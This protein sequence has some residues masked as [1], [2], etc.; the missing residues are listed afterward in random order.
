VKLTDPAALKLT[1]G[2]RLQLRRRRV[3][4][5]LVLPGETGQARERDPALL[6]A[7]VRGYRWFKELTFE[8]G[9]EAAGIAKREGVVAKLEFWPL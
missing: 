8:A 1:R 9:A 7:V 5:R 4:T 2:L 6:K 3:E